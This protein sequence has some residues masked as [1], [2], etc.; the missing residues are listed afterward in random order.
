LRPVSDLNRGRNLGIVLVSMMLVAATSQAWKQVV[1]AGA[2]KDRALKTKRF[3]VT[4]KEFPKRGTIISANGRILAQSTDTYELG[5]NFK[6]VPKSESFFMA[7]GQASQIPAIE[8]SG[9]ARSGGKSKQWTGLISSERAKAIQTVQSHWD[10]DGIS[11]RRVQSRQ[12]PFGEAFESVIGSFGEEKAP[13]GLESS[14][15]AVL[16]G[17]EGLREGM[18]DRR[19]E[20][21]PMRMT[22]RDRRAVDGQDIT[23]TLDSELQ[24][25]AQASVKQAVIANNADQGMAVVLEPHTGRLL[26]LVSYVLG[27]KEGAG[28]GYNPAVMG[29][30]EPGSIFKVF[31][32]ALAIDEGKVRLH[33][34]VQC[35]GSMGIGRRARIHC[36]HTHGTVDARDA[37]AK[38]CNVAAAQWAAKIGHDRF[39][40]FIKEAG[41]LDAR[42]IGLPKEAKGSY[43]DDNGNLPLN[44]ANFG[45]GQSTSF[46][47]LGLASVLNAFASDGNYCPPR[48]VDKIGG[49]PEPAARKSE[50][51]SPGTSAQVLDLMRSTFESEGGTA[52]S[53]RIPGYSLAG[54]TGTA[55]KLSAQYTDGKSRYV[56]NF[57]GFV[58][59]DRPAATVLIMIDNPKAGKYYGGSV[60]GPVFQDIAKAVIKR[61][62]LPKT[63]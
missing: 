17:Q 21:L 22:D 23:V 61:Y 50:L 47:P 57:V 46:S 31:T 45:F 12:Y 29:V 63:Q 5:I 48:L 59:G 60:A 16:K 24:M 9:P 49:R 39:T 44:L 42:G 40:E 37:I 13:T 8:F 10:A 53:L 20:Y 54:K 25:A 35:S 3:L 52:H 15:M 14:K 34:T 43:L 18:M 30:F 28:N 19:Q 58:P 38:S 2:T 27:Q 6:K 41:L 32:L 11:L 36:T 55:Q 51:F 56:S 62:N 7:L 4:R 26:A 1:T 33:D